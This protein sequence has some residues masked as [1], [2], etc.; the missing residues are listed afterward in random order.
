MDL[1]SRGGRA[2]HISLRLTHVQG[3]PFIDG[4][5]GCAI[6]FEGED[7]GGDNGGMGTGEQTSNPHV[8]TTGGPAFTHMTVLQTENY[9]DGAIT[10]RI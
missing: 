5:A 1:G 7:Q 2:G 9:P 4:Y 10:M 6:V 8:L 3:E